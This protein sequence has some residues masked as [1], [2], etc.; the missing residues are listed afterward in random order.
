MP[1]FS[2]SFQYVFFELQLLNISRSPE[3]HTHPQTCHHVSTIY[4][5]PCAPVDSPGRSLICL[6]VNTLPHAQTAHQH[7]HTPSLQQNDDGICSNG[8]TAQLASEGSPFSFG[9]WRVSIFFER[10]WNSGG[11]SN[12]LGLLQMLLQ[13]FCSA[14][15]SDYIV[16][17]WTS[18]AGWPFGLHQL[19]NTGNHV[20]WGTLNELSGR[21]RGCLPVGTVLPPPSSLTLTLI[22]NHI[23]GAFLPSSG[24]FP[25]LEGTRGVTS[26]YGVRCPICCNL[27]E[28]QETEQLTQPSWHSGLTFTSSDMIRPICSIKWRLFW[29]LSLINIAYYPKNISPWIIHPLACNTNNWSMVPCRK[30][31]EVH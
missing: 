8:N 28:T 6:S 21:R 30:L 10:L 31:L 15:C 9:H 23:S 2:N 13:M 14:S 11:Q 3:S 27:H 12:G 17:Q 29:K 22:Y 4:K 7:V 19:F 25:E 26:S 24:I 5:A 1:L 18:G 16:Y 20:G